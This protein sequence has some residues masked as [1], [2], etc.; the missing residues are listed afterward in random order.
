MI[1]RSLTI[2][3]IIDLY[4]EGESTKKI[5][6]KAGVSQRYI[7]MLLSKHN[8]QKRPHGS[9]KRKHNLNEHYFKKWS[10]NMAYILGFFCAD[11]FIATD[12]QSVSISQKERSIL[13]RI[14]SELESNQPLY[15]NSDSGVYM[16]HFHSKIIKDDL[17]T[18][19][20]ITPNKSHTLKFPKIPPVY[21]SHFIRGY[22]DG[23]GFVKY[24]RS[25]VSFVGGSRLFMNRLKEIIETLGFDTE[26]QQFDNCYRLFLTGRKSI[27]KFSRWIY[28][29]KDLYLERKFH[30]FSKENLPLEKLKD[31]KLKRTKTAVKARK[32]KFLSLVNNRNS[33]DEA[34]KQIGIQ[35]S[36]FKKWISSDMQFKEKFDQSQS[37]KGK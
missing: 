27:Q 4:N 34:I 23:Y 36:T 17:I 28:K 6:E 26:L 5:A 18:L 12:N 35:K 20:G 37:N 32:E 30:E 8:V 16:L 13:L 1:K 24:E 19:H 25:V 31:N 33:I 10:N 7:R 15:Y 29:D 2:E 11:G 3:R 21:L 22:F 14:R 9:W